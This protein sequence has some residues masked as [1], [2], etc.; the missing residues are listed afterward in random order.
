MFE[1]ALCEVCDWEWNACVSFFRACRNKLNSRVS[2]NEFTI[3]W[4][5]CYFCPSA[6]DD[7]QQAIVQTENVSTFNMHIAMCHMY[8]GTVWNPIKWIQKIKV[9]RF[10]AFIICYV[11]VSYICVWACARCISSS[12]RANVI[13]S[14]KICTHRSANSNINNCANICRATYCARTSFICSFPL[15]KL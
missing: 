10:V 5:N 1:F 13:D 2:W 4:A 6:P 3:E 8:S 14:V 7:A 9:F 15:I 11:C 12:V